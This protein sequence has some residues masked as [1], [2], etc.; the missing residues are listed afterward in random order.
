MYGLLNVGSLV[1]GLIAWIL[2][3][4]SLTKHNK[5]NNKTWVL[6]SIAS[7]SACVI[8]LLFQILY[9]DYLVRIEAWVALMDT[10]K[11]VVRLSSLLAVVTIVLNVI[12]AIVYNKKSK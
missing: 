8:S 10:S 3:I 4:A 2:P 1:L 12:T 11:A 9:N 5:D 7:I 6:F